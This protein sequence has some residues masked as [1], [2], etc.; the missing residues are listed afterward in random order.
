MDDRVRFEFEELGGVL[1]SR[2]EIGRAPSCWPAIGLE[3]WNEPEVPR[4]RRTMLPARED[5]ELAAAGDDPAGAANGCCDGG[6]TSTGDDE[7][8][9][10]SV[11]PVPASPSPPRAAGLAGCSRDVPVAGTSVEV[12][13]LLEGE[14]KGDSGS[15]ASSISSRYG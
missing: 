9:L 1:L 5:S 7:P 14:P 3:P 6:G 15:K 2:R 8:S 10:L 12:L 13:R 11:T 4:G